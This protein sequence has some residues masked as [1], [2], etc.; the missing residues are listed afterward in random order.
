MTTRPAAVMKPIFTSAAPTIQDGTCLAVS[1]VSV[2]DCEAAAARRSSDWSRVSVSWCR[3]VKYAA[4]AT[5]ATERPTAI[6][7]SSV[8]RLASERR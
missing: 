3:T 1:S 8:T 6:V 2:L 4:A 5:T 7:A